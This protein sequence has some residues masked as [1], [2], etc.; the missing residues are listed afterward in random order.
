MS[1]ELGFSKEHRDLNIQRIGYV[2]GL[3]SG[4]GGIA[5]TAAIAPY[6]DTRETAKELVSQSGGDFVEVFVNADVETCENRDVKGLYKAARA[7]KIP[8]F[9]GVSDPYEAPET[10][11]LEIKTGDMSVSESIDAVIEYLKEQKYI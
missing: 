6:R 11:D 3:V 2:A 1:S 9:T 5:L 4:A 8:Q 7:G 10:P